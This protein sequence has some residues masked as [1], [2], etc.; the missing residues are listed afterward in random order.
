[1]AADFQLQHPNACRHVASGIFGSKFVT[2]VI[3]GRTSR[4]DS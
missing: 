2:V 3:T 1:M 4:R